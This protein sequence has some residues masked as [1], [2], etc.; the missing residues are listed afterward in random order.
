MSYSH[1]VT[2]RLLAGS[3][4]RFKHFIDDVISLRNGYRSGLVNRPDGSVHSADVGP[5]DFEGDVWEVSSN[6]SDIT[7]GMSSRRGRDPWE[8]V[9]LR[10]GKI[11]GENAINER[12]M[13]GSIYLRAFTRDTTRGERPQVDPSRR[14]TQVEVAEKGAP[15][16]VIETVKF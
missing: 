13:M 15:E 7:V 2:L 4:E 3:A 10:G 11:V 16:I 8:N 6:Y 12:P 9:S 1:P 14:Q 5:G